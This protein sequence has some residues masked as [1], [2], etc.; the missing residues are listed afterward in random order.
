MKNIG[1]GVHGRR[2]SASRNEK[3][4]FLKRNYRK[5]EFSELSAGGGARNSN[6]WKEFIEKIQVSEQA[7]GGRG[8]AATKKQ[9][10]LKGI[11]WK[12]EVLELSAGGGGRAATKNSNFEKEF[13]EKNMVAEFASGSGMYPVIQPTAPDTATALQC[14]PL[15]S[16]KR[17]LEIFL[18]PCYIW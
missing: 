13:I 9:Q 12:I 4:Q 16:I 2:R 5:F 8:W 11:Y 7:A 18:E 17:V 1:F 3:Q 15:S 14:M 6:F 10:F